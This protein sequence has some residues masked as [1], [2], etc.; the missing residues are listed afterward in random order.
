MSGSE[1]F[2]AEGWCEG[3]WDV[4][5]MPFAL[6]ALALFL[7]EDEMRV[8]LRAQEGGCAEPLAFA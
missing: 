7:G 8:G 2:R 3:T 4:L 5:P 6:L 1:V